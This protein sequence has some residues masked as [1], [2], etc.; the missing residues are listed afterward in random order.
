MQDTRIIL[1]EVNLPHPR[2]PCCDMWVLSAALNGR[3][4]NTA[5]CDKGA[6]RKRHKLSVEEMRVSIEQDFWV[7]VFP[8]ASVSSFK[9]LGRTLMT[10]EDDW[11]AVV[12]NLCKSRTKWDRMLRIL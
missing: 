10:S 5:Q 11:P 9:Y 2:C 7:Y 12:G 4:P 8:L 1:E 6:N 3:H